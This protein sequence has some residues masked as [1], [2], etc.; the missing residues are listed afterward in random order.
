[1]RQIL[2]I[3]EWQARGRLNSGDAT[4][5][6]DVVRL[7]VCWPRDYLYIAKGAPDHRW[8]YEKFGRWLSQATVPVEMPHISIDETNQ[9]HFT[10]GRHR[11]AWMRDHGAK[12][13]PVTI[14]D[15]EAGVL[16]ELA[17]TELRECR[18]EQTQRVR[19]LRWI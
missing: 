4:V 14:C 15:R 12:A 6:I 1:M 8:G 18:I 10:N 2:W 17:G 7:E 9:I 13:L 11:F 19:R 3:P 16:S 5:W